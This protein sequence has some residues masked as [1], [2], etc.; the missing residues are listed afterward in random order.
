MTRTALA[1]VSLFVCVNAWPQQ[2]AADIERGMILGLSCAACH[3]TGGNSPGAIP[4][5]AGKKKAFIA[6]SLRNFRDDRKKATVMNR[7]AKG[8]TDAEIEALAE[9]FSKSQ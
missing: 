6:D 1:A 4:S 5:I 2:A 9:Y 7:I 3:G 8:Y